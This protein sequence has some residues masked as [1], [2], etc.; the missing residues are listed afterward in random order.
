[1]SPAAIGSLGPECYEGME[2]ASPV[3]MLNAVRCRTVLEDMPVKALPSREGSI[4]LVVYVFIF[5]VLVSLAFS[6]GGGG[7]DRVSLP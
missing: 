4:K 1:M 2:R 5:I 6:C 3:S 7:D